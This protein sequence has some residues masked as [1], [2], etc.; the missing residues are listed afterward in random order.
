VGQTVDMT[1]H[2]KKV[3]VGFGANLGDPLATYASAKRLLEQRLGPILM[4]SAVY[5]SAALTIEGSESQLN[6]FNAALVFESLLE[7][8]Q[9][10]EVLLQTETVFKRSRSD[11]LRWAPRPIDLDI[12]FME[13]TVVDQPG[14]TIPHPEAHN[15]DFVLCPLC[16]VAPDLIHPTYAKT[17]KELESSLS[18]RGCKRLIIGIKKS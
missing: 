4:E 18:A 11:A 2:P 1:K 9:I 15:R 12:L 5:E 17:I 14:L 3:Y 7:P 8:Q 16:D 10:L 6:Y 13:D